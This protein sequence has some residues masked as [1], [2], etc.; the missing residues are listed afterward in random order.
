MRANEEWIVMKNLGAGRLIVGIVQTHQRIPEKR[1]KLAAG[2]LK[3][4]RRSQEIE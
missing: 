2:G 4:R 1:G 3:L